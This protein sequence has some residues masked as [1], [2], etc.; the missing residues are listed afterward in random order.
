MWI[1]II[2]SILVL[3]SFPAISYLDDCLERYVDTG[4]WTWERWH[5]P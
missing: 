3:G 5:T 2:G 4:K 1:F